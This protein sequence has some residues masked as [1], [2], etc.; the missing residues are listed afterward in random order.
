MLVELNEAEQRLA[1]FLAKARYENA[2]SKNIPNKKIGPQS[3]ELTDLE[4]IAGELAFCKLM[5]VYPNLQTV[6][7][8]EDD[9][10]LLNGLRVDVKTTKYKNGRVL[11]ASWKEEN[12]IDVYALMVGEFPSYRFAG[13]ISAKKLLVEERKINLGHGVGYAA[14]QDELEKWR[15]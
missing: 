8:P 10:L 5:N 13:M 7:I 9:C 14:T 1:K 4:G 11:A 12:T 15:T 3:N 2:R 6:V